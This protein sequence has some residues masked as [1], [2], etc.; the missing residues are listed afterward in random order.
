MCC[1]AGLQS[2]YAKQLLLSFSMS[3]MQC[4][5]GCVLSRAALTISPCFVLMILFPFAVPLLRR[6]ADALPDAGLRRVLTARLTVQDVALR[7]IADH[8]RALAEVMPWK[9]SIYLLHAA[10][11]RVL[12]V[13]F[14]GKQCCVPAHVWCFKE[15]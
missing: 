12:N 14:G 15:R 3:S 2:W 9:V 7:L 10:S 8:R 11:V 13:K 4:S 1:T 6:L 5:A